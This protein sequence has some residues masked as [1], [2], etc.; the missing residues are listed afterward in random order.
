MGRLMSYS[1]FRNI[2]RCLLVASAFSLGVAG[3]N[4]QRMPN[5]TAPSGDTLPR[6]D[7]FLGYSYFNAHGQVQPFNIPYSSIPAGGVLSGAYFLTHHVG[8]EASF[9]LHHGSGD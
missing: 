1:P 3:L 8:A 5:I 4:A 6:Y 2:G 7:I 9:V